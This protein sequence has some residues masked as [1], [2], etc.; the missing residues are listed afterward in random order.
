TG[1]VIRFRPKI[2]G[3]IVGSVLGIGAFLLQG[4]WWTWQMLAL[5]LVAVVSLVIPGYLYKKY[6]SNGV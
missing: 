3:G 4:E 1:E 2:I 5:S 6:F